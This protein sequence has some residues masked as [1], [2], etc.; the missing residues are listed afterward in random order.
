MACQVDNGL[1]SCIAQSNDIGH[2]GRDETAGMGLL[3]PT[4]IRG[5]Q[6]GKELG[7]HS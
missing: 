1:C 5:H 2:E 6:F 7:L 3:Y 4:K